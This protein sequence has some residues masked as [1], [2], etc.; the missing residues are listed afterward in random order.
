MRVQTFLSEGAVEAFDLG[1]VRW[2]ARSAGLRVRLDTS[3]RISLLLSR[4][5]SW[6]RVRG[7]EKGDDSTSMA[8]SFASFPYHWKY[9]TLVEHKVQSEQLVAVHW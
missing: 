1:V 8:V 5:T 9:R 4:T 2:R 6:V 3:C 7:Q